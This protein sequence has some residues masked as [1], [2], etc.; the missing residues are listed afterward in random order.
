MISAQRGGGTILL[1]ACFL[2]TGTARAL[3]VAAANAVVG[4]PAPNFSAKDIEGKTQTLDALRGRVVVLE[5]VNPECPFVRK[6]YGSGNMQHLQQ[7]WTTQGVVWLSVNSSAAGKQG[8]LTPTT[9]KEF[10]AAQR[11]APTQMLLD[12][13]GVVGRLYG[14]KTTPHVFII[15]QR[16]M[17][18]YAGAIDDTPS[19]NPADIEGATNYVERALGEVM[20]KKAVSISETRSYGCAVKY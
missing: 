12:P 19:T 2:Y 9:A 17:L 7:K 20:A 4:S 13:D 5:W 1:A 6:H 10:L 8:H 16:G 11:A 18:V 15:D 14:A 3:S